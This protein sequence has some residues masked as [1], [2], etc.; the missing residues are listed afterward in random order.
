LLLLLVVACASLAVPSSA[1]GDGFP[2]QRH[3]D[4]T[5]GAHGWY[6]SNVHVYWTFNPTPASS[7]GCDAKTLTTDGV[8]Q[9]HCVAMWT[10]PTF[11]FDDLFTVSIDKTPPAVHGV[12]SRPPDANGWY[13]KPVAISFA[14]TDAR[15]GIAGCSSATYSGPANATAVVSGSCTDKAG[16]VGQASVSFAYDSTPPASLGDVTVKHEDKAVLL[17]WK[18]SADTKTVQ[19]T[20]SG[21]KD[22]PKL[23]YSG[24]ASSFQDQ[25]LRPGAK[26][27]YTLTAFDAASNST[28]DKVGV[29]ATGRLIDPFPGE[30]VTSP[31]RLFW[32]PVKGASYYNVQLIKGHRVLS[33]WP[34]RASFKVPHK[35]VYRGH[36]YKLRHGVYRWYVWPGIGV[37]ARAKYGRLIGSSTFRYAG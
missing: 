16:N 8:T 11:N 24:S 12:V 1:P 6:V 18:A 7:T 29:T 22:A 32:V 25:G 4:G 3:V 31:P 28:A 35:W 26:Y 17:S 9:F 36:H 5:L 13:N 37:R 19:V 20:R 2:A 27:K 10:S 23:V 33:A 15:S 30:S 14:G 21:A 34:V